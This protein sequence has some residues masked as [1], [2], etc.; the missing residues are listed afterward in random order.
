MNTE[1]SPQAL[2]QGGSGAPT[3]STTTLSSQRVTL[4]SRRPPYPRRRTSPRRRR[5]PPR[6]TP[7]PP[8]PPS[9]KRRG[10][11]SHESFARV[12][13]GRHGFL[14]RDR[15]HDRDAPCRVVGLSHPNPSPGRGAGG[16]GSS[17][18]GG[19]V[20]AKGTYID[21]PEGQSFSG[22]VATFTDSYEFSQESD[23]LTQINWGDGS[24]DSYGYVSDQGNG[25]YQITGTHTYM[26]EGTHTTTVTV[27]D[28]LSGNVCAVNGTIV[29]TDA[30]IEL[31]TVAV[32]AVAGQSFT[33]LLG[34][35]GPA[36][37]D[38][39]PT[40]SIDWGD[41]TS[42]GSGIVSQTSI[43]GA[44]T[45]ALPGSYVITFTALED[46]QTATAHVEASVAAASMQGAGLPITATEG[47]AFSG[48]VATFQIPE[49]ISPGDVNAG[50]FTATIDW[51]GANG[52]SSSGTVVADGNYGEYAVEGT[53]TYD[54]EGAAT[55]NV[56][57]SGLGT[58]AIFTGSA[59]I[60]GAPLT[61]QL[62]PFSAVESQAMPDH[63]PVAEFQDVD[64]ANQSSVYAAVVDWGDG[65]ISAGLVVNGTA[66]GDF[67]VEAAH[68]YSEDGLYHPS[69]T[70]EDE[71]ASKLLI[72]GDLTVA[73]A[74]LSVYG[75]SQWSTLTRQPWYGMIGTFGEGLYDPTSN[76]TATIDWGDGSATDAGHIY[77]P[78][79]VP[80]AYLQSSPTWTAGNG[81]GTFAVFGNHTYT[82][83]AGQT[84]WTYTVSLTVQDNDGSI[85]SATDAITVYAGEPSRN[86]PLPPD[87]YITVTAI[88][89]TIMEGQLFSGVVATFTYNPPTPPANLTLSDFG[90][91]VEWG[92]A[93]FQGQNSQTDD[94]GATVVDNGDG[95]YSVVA[96]HTFVDEGPDH[97]TNEY[98]FT[99]YVGCILELPPYGPNDDSA[100]ATVP[101]AP[102]KDVTLIPD[103]AALAAT[104]GQ[105]MPSAV[106]ASFSATD[107]GQTGDFS[108]VIDFGDGSDPVTG[109]VVPG[110][111]G[112]E[113]IA[114]AHVYVEDGG[115]EMNVTVT[116]SY[117]SGQSI[118][119]YSITITQTVAVADAAVVAIGYQGP[120]LTG[121]PRA[122]PPA[123]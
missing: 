109:T 95:T 62:L 120:I 97:T 88:P 116:R 85:Q 69:V 31:N 42:A 46:G 65:T 23:F 96:N 115:Y 48:T 39:P 122:S 37:P 119:P 74:P 80:D 78:A 89:I 54:E 30:P 13:P 14:R 1:P 19:V 101:E 43:L 98:T 27:T 82:L 17:P 2:S 47:A 93:P 36:E 57:V 66:P 24:A 77:G 6:R 49:G 67:I 41:G 71:G 4:C 70:V 3:S 10:R 21:P 25:S 22:V 44:H 110:G 61:G 121:A 123:R 38:D 15:V 12:F 73:D 60:L 29:V 55:V 32:D 79:D 91:W 51:G 106:V 86:E 105:T 114:P 5:T 83:P 50:D 9:P 63:T 99:V 92:D 112:F 111:V 68:T 113:V 33:A 53:N 20:T 108:A 102:I 11:A 59:L 104:E 72:E 107:G 87:P 90:A 52:T 84:Q 76:F 103:P 18:S 8:S 26:D 117:V 16:R 64:T 58:S 56:T 100:T 35:Y 34:S 75:G 81:T 40:V 28:V 45:Y 7:D 118:P 94:G